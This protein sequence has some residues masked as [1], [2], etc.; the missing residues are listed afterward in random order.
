[1]PLSSVTTNVFSVATRLL[2]N[3][4]NTWR[5]SIFIV[6]MRRNVRP[7]KLWLKNNNLKRIVCKKKE[8]NVN[9]NANKNNCEKFKRKPSQKKWN[10][11]P[12]LEIG[13]KVISK[14]DEKELA[15]FDTEAIMIKQVEE[16]ENEKRQLIARLKAQEKK[17]DHLERAKRKEEIPLIKESMTQDEE[18]D[19]VIWKDK[20]EERIKTAKE[21]REE[22]VKTRD[23][24]IRMAADKNAFMEKLLKERQADFDKK[25]DDYT[26]SVDEARATRLEERKEER[27]DERRKKWVKE[28]EEESQRRYDEELIRQR[29]EKERLEAERKEAE[30]EEYRKKKEA[31]D[32]IAKRQQERE[33]EIEERDRQRDAE[34]K[35]QM[36]EQRDREKSASYDRPGQGGGRSAEPEGGDW[37]ASRERDDRGSS[38]R[39]GPRSS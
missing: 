12:K 24:L 11:L 17:V 28:Q 30:E 1:M 22:A 8:K 27:K 25:E 20:E 21:E 38:R 32:A 26:K 19:K 3:V 5:N 29:E 23:R 39:G 6:K 36:Q 9:F 37:R 33:K 18:E 14:M 10:K 2:K 7:P 16:L 31:L 35:Q 13:K 34:K 4:K 15:E